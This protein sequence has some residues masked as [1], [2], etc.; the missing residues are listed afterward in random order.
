M[1]EEDIRFLQSLKSDGSPTMGFFIPLAT[2]AQDR[3][4][5]RAKKNGWAE[6]DRSVWQWRI[7]DAGLSALRDGGGEK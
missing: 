4:R 5:S 6:F 2:R 1:T 7:T 3:A